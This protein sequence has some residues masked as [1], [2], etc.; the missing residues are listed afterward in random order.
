MN[1]D[2]VPLTV[3]QE[4]HNREADWNLN[5]NDKIWDRVHVHLCSEKN[6]N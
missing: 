2:G 5:R 6:N 4:H 1:V 3:R